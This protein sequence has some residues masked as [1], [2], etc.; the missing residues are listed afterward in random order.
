MRLITEHVPLQGKSL[1]KNMASAARG[2]IN[3]YLLSWGPQTE[4]IQ[5]VKQ[6]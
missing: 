6:S 3:M 5:I 1:S 2:A 4:K